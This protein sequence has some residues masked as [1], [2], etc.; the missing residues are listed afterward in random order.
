LV[1]VLYPLLSVIPQE[2]IFRKFFFF[3]YGMFFTPYVLIVLNALVFSFVHL[4]FKNYI[5]LVLTFVGGILFITTYI[6]TKS[7]SLVCIEHAL[8]GDLLFTIGLGV[9]HEIKSY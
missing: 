5:A 4:V 3:R 6:K 9:G 2:L 1:I 8:Y 7:F